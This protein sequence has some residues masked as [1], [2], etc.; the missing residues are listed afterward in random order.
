MTARGAR[1]ARGA[2]VTPATTWS[3]AAVG[4][5]ADE[6]GLRAGRVLREVEHDGAEL[7]GADG[8]VGDEAGGGGEQV[9]GVVPPTGQAL[10]GLTVQAD[11]LT[12]QRTGV[13]HGAKG[14]VIDVAQLLVGPG[15]RP[16][17]RRVLGDRSELPWVGAQA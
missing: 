2:P 17:R 13:G 8:A 15:E 4:Q 14:G 16:G 12:G 1:S 10:G 11:H 7:V 9:G 3:S 5:R 6:G